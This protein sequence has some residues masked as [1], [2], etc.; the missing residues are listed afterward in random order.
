MKLYTYF[1]YRL[2]MFFITHYDIEDQPLLKVATTSSL[3]IS[4]NLISLYG[5][6]KLKSIIPKFSNYTVAVFILLVIFFIN[7][8]FFIR[9]KAFLKYNFRNDFLGGMVILIYILLSIL[10]F[11]YTATLN[12][13]SF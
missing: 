3:L 2:Y 13:K 8:Y 9:K 1:L 6:M 12:R 7:Y 4:I 10:L 5:L 11:V